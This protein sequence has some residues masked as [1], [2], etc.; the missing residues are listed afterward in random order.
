MAKARASSR[1]PKRAGAQ[2]AAGGRKS[3]AKRMP[4]SRRPPR[5][6]ARGTAGALRR[7][8][9]REQEFRLENVGKEPVLSEH[10]VTNPQTGGTCRVAIRGT[11][12]GERYLG[13]PAPEPE[14]L[15]MIADLL[16]RLAGGRQARTP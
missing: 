4:R 12:P 8:F 3:A 1:Q 15:R 6:D 5:Y 9:G 11:S 10:T 16:G 7:E 2:K 13:L 14:M